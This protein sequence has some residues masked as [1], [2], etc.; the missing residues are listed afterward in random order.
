VIDSRK[1]RLGAR[2]NAF[3]KDDNDQDFART[4]IFCAGAV[5]SQ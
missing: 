5:A 4:R 2:A 1:K 3:V